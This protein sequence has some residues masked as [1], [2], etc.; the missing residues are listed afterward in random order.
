MKKCSTC[1]RI[2]SEPR[3]F[4]KNTSRWRI[5]SGGNLFFNCS[6]ESTLVIP[7]G[8]YDW[9]NPGLFMGEKARSIFNNLSAPE[10]IPYLP[11]A[12]IELQ[13][14][15]NNP[16]SSAGQ[17]AQLCKQ[18]PALAANII[19]S[20]NTMRQVH[21]KA[22]TSIEQAIGLLGRKRLA[23]L[24]VTAALSQFPFG[25]TV[26]PKRVYFEESFLTGIAAEYLVR[27]FGEKLSADLAYVSGSFCNVG[28]ILSATAYPEQTD[29][30]YSTTENLNSACD[31]STAEA[32]AGAA[33]HTV[34]GEIA[35]ALWGL[36][37]AV[38][39]CAQHHHDVLTELTAE[40][41]PILP[42]VTFANQITHFAHFS[43]HRVQTA[44]LESCMRY[45]SLTQDKLQK[46]IE[47]LAPFGAQI[48]EQV[49]RMCP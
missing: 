30:I 35:C 42:Y 45:F 49:A 48:R 29:K 44:V 4:L 6:C 37:P 1:G 41:H 16:N 21:T 3:D 28:K 2:Y 33:E 36:D 12:A 27:H 14:A 7:K 25:C 9:Y 11:A 17:L 13:E 43:S 15:L 46:I 10:S 39:I 40:R 24:A 5:C 18:D 32:R 22:A 26:Y 19:A 47:D 8:K 31:W 20:A 38:F 23:T 34:L